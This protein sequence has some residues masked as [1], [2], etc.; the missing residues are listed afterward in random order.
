[1]ICFLP[2][3]CVELGLWFS[4]FGFL[5]VLGYFFYWEYQISI[6]LVFRG[7]YGIFVCESLVL[8]KI[9]W[10]T[11]L[12]YRFVGWSRW[13]N[14]QACCFEFI[15]WVVRRVHLVVCNGGQKDYFSW[16][17]T[18]LTS[19]VVFSR[20]F[21]SIQLKKWKYDQY[22]WGYG[23][24]SSC[25]WVRCSGIFLWF[26]CRNQLVVRVWAPLF[27]CKVLC[28]VFVFEPCAEIMRGF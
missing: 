12:F 23:L 27:F 5:S 13:T 22:C 28:F 9:M 26:N 18:D 17:E 2:R 6:P 3:I 15:R 24:S 19:F 1:M 11:I 20:F 25:L 21:F 8:G 14:R 10:N 4:C 16:K 7:E